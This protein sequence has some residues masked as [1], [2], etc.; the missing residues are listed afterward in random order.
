MALLSRE[1]GNDAG[2]IASL[3]RQLLS[4]QSV[5]QID[6]L[7]RAHHHLE[8]RDEAGL[9]ER[10]DVDAVELDALDLFFEFE[11]R[12]GG[13]APFAHISKARAA[14]HLLRAREIF[15]GDVAAALRRMHDRTFE[16]RIGVKQVPQR[17]AVVGLHVAVPLVEAGQ[18]HRKSPMSGRA[19]VRSGRTQ[20]T[21]HIDAYAT[22]CIMSTTPNEGLAC[23][24][25]VTQ[26]SH[27]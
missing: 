14:Q 16:H 11:H 15:K 24:R 10:D 5:Q 2:P 21:M 3:L 4:H 7:E 25:S 26:S 17:R 18:G 8:M 22:L 23:W 1:L 19:W 27:A 12:A 9:V 13:A 20:I 6:R